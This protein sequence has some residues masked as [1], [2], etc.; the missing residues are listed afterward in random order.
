MRKYF[1]S[2]FDRNV[3]NMLSHRVQLQ[4]EPSLNELDHLICDLYT[5]TCMKPEY[6]FLCQEDLATI[7]K[8]LRHAMRDW[9]SYQYCM[10]HFAKSDA[11]EAMALAREYEHAKRIFPPVG[12]S[13][14]LI[15]LSDL[16]KG[17][18][19]LGFYPLH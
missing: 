3:D 18:V 5:Q 11:I 6:I 8:E 19:I 1:I 2:G 12:G 16:P 4:G 14:C 10:R 13:A 15:A 17:T 9:N 7:S